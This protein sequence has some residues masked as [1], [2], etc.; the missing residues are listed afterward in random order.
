ML[1]E[2]GTS[3]IQVLTSCASASSLTGPNILISRRTNI[4][5]CHPLLRAWLMPCT[6]L[7][8]LNPCES[9][10]HRFVHEIPIRITGDTVASLEHI[11][12]KDLK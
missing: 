9:Q 6:I 1:S 7:A 4:N 12:M 2:T 8:A 5:P 10:L 11:C 3:S